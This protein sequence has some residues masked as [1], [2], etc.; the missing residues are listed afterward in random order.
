MTTPVSGTDFND[1]FRGA[2]DMVLARLNADYG[3]L[4][5]R[6]LPV[7]RT[8]AALDLGCGRGEWLQLAAGWGLQAHGVDLDDAA[9]ARCHSLGLS[10]THA[11]LHAALAGAPEGGLGLITAFQVVEHMPWD[12][13]QRLLAEALRA[14]EPGGLLILE[15]PNP[16]NILVSTRRFHLDPTHVRLIPLDLLAHALQQA[17]YAAVHVLRL[18]EDPRIAADAAPTV[19]DV[20]DG[21]SPDYAVVAQKAGRPAQM[22]VVRQA[23]AGAGAGLTLE[24]VAARHEQRLADMQTCLQRVAHRLTMADQQLAT[25]QQQLAE[26]QQQRA[27]QQQQL[28]EQQQQLAMHQ[29]RLEQAQALRHELDAVYASRS[30]R[31]T[32]PLRWL[33]ALLRRIEQGSDPGRRAVGVL[34]NVVQHTPGLQPTLRA[35]ALPPVAEL[36]ARWQEDANQLPEAR[37][38]HRPAPDAPRQLLLDVSALVQHDPRTGIQRVSRSLLVELLANPPP[39]FRVEPVRADTESEGYRY[40]HRWL[41]A[42]RGE[43]APTGGDAPVQCNAGDVFLGVDLRHLEVVF[44][45]DYLMRL[46][47]EGVSI[48]FVVYDLLPVFLPHRFDLPRGTH[49]A[50]LGAVASFDGAWCISKAV[51]DELAGWLQANPGRPRA[52]PL[53]IGHFHLGAD[54]ENSVPSTGIPDDAAAVLGQLAAHPSFLMVGTLEP[55][56]GH[57][58]VLDAFELLWREGLEA[59][60]VLVGKHGWLVDALVARLAAHPQAGQRLFWLRQISD[61]YLERVYAHCRCLIAASEGEGFGLPLIEAARHGLPIIAR[62]IPVFRE[63]AGEHALFF[64]GASGADLARAVQTWLDLDAAGKAPPSGGMP[65]LTWAQST[66]Q[67]LAGLLGFPLR[68][69]WY[70][71]D[72]PEVS[73]IVLNHDKPAMTLACVESLW[74]HTAGYRYEIV[75]VDNGS[76][77]DNV[78]L[79]RGRGPGLR[80][81]ETGVNRFFGE[82]NNLGAEAARGRWLVFLNNDVFA[83]AGWLPPLIDRLRRD[84]ELGAVGPRLLSMDGRLQEAGAE[85]L[86]SGDDL[87]FGQGKPG[88]TPMHADQDVMFVSAA[89]LAMPRAVFEDVLG[90]DLRYEPAYY[91]DCDLC[92]KV[93]QRGQR[94]VCCPDSA[95]IHVGNV[96][97]H[98]MLGEQRLAALVALNR[99]RFLARWQAVLDGT[100]ASVSGLLPVPSAAARHREGLPSVLLYTPY[101]LVPGGGERYLLSIA[102]ALS[103]AA[104]VTLATP[105]AWS[106]LRLRT[107]GRELQLDLDAVRMSTWS[108]AL[109]SE[110]WDLQITLGNEA[111]PA[112]PGRARRNVFVCQFPFPTPQ[113]ELMRWLP[114]LA[115]YAETWVYS[116]FVAAHLQQARAAL[117]VAESR[118]EIMEPPCPPVSADLSL[119]RGPI[120]LGVGRFFAGGHNKRHDLMI[121][122]LRELLPS[123]PGAQLH[124]AGTVPGEQEHR[125]HYAQLREAA[126][127]LPVHFHPNVDPQQLAALYRSASLYWHCA[128]VG[129]D[130][131]AEPQRCE[132]FGITV[133]EAMSAGC[134]ALVPDRGGPPGIVQDGVTGHVFGS[135]PALVA[136]SVELLQ[137][138]PDDAALAAMR[139]AA[140]AAARRYAPE[141]FAE[142]VLARCGLQPAE[143]A[144]PAATQRPA[145]VA[146]PW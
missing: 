20:L 66:Q 24:T 80:L 123:C 92:L 37:L 101:D 31:I 125:E 106:R 51:A 94:V 121:E 140:V 55:R 56:K 137:R 47:H 128:G 12:V 23:L 117:G 67:L 42:L 60:L 35:I 57:A 84:P 3:T 15:T 109:R 118:I 122:A 88:D 8:R 99:E 129:V 90:F 110:A 18:H 89:A 62:D 2:E 83:T 131:A 146:P 14:L 100:Q 95:I 72:E 6:W 69:E 9:L 13:L 28:A 75:L 93:L 127:G 130:V 87:H 97:T 126:A 34:R 113:A 10:A 61:E 54:I 53:R 27:E 144:A 22:E 73:L 41:A 81:V 114:T 58:Q 68:D 26:Q 112:V 1:C 119:A 25:L 76:S 44:Q 74:Q 78:A 4:V 70:S 132:H 17:G 71:E 59:N 145:Q 141:A 36:R 111:L 38:L 134:I 46:R 43:P 116:G 21:A 39:G 49:E 139:A 143:G 19:L 40:A 102:S 52:L 77:P 136:R 5:Q 104:N 65:W 120:I 7:C 124:L 64:D 45:H 108:A 30:W 103:R 11:D 133:V 33:A 86:P 135:L 91:E 48:N 63:V 105:W 115:D 98:A 82:G 107:L 29:Q 79:L 138:P 142:A 96:T 85:I 50:W 32:R 16:E